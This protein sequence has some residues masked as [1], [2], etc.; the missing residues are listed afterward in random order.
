MKLKRIIAAIIAMLMLFA[1]ACAPTSDGETTDTPQESAT[2]RADALSEYV[3]VVSEDV[4]DEE[5]AAV[6]D[7][8]KKIYEKFGVLL[9]IVDDA[10]SKADKE[11]LVGEV[12]R[13][14]TESV[15][16]TMKYDDYFLGI[17]DEKLLVVGGSSSATAAAI[18]KLLEVVQTNAGSEIFF[19]NGANLQDYK[20]SYTHEDIKINGV[21]VSEYTIMYADGGSRREATMAKTLQKAII[22]VCGVVVTTQPDTLGAYGNVIYFGGEATASTLRSDGDVIYVTGAN[23]NDVFFATQTLVAR[24][25][26]SA[27]GSVTV[28]AEESLQNTL[29]DLDLSKWGVSQEKIKVMSYNLQNAGNGSTSMTKYRNLASMIDSKSPDFVAVQECITS[30]S[31]AENLVSAMADKTKYAA[32]T[33]TGITTAVIYN[34]NK[35]TFIEKGVEAIG[36]KDDKYGSAYDRNMM[37]TKL[38]S[39]ATGAEFIVLSVHIDYVKAANVVQLNLILDYM[40]ENFAELPAV[41]LGDYNTEKKAL[42][43]ASIE[44]A[45]YV[46]CRET[47]TVAVNATVPTFPSDNSVIDYIFAKGMISEYYETLTSENNPSDHR[48]IYAELYIG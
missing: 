8:V 16:K 26:E 15:R 38:R 6:S 48:P 11:I 42:D 22:S 13:E 45:G 3:V 21:S 25:C 41:L 2:I 33:T 4:S 7:A 5:K 40:Q 37:W 19:D 47:A 9:K 32:V 34:K 36:K 30:G 10:I 12:N 44:K 35:Y 29:A 27:D 17:V 31:G 1:T 14:Q 23:E 43:V 24:V 39:N 46:D 28:A 20:H 18:E